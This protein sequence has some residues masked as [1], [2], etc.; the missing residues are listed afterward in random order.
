MLPIEGLPC[1]SPVINVDNWLSQY[2]MELGRRPSED[3]SFDDVSLVTCCLLICCVY[4][5]SL[6]LC[7][8]WIIRKNL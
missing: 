1:V 7:M 5:Y 3:L 2:Q 8:V 4:N 6:K